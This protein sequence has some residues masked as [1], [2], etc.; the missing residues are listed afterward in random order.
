MQYQLEL[1]EKFNYRN[2]LIVFHFYYIANNNGLPFCFH[3]ITIA[4]NKSLSVV[5]LTV[6]YMTLLNQTKKKFI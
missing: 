1:D 6:T 3:Q 5:D 2:E 4:Q